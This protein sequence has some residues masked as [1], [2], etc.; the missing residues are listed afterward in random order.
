MGW[1]AKTKLL[2]HIV[3]GAWSVRNV[4]KVTQYR[5]RCC[6]SGHTQL[7]FYTALY[8]CS[9]VRHF[10]HSFGFGLEP[11]LSELLD[12]YTGITA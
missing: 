9:K 12:N 2:V 11:V 10:P 5:A 6:T 7:P 1:L 4:A 3:E 8:W